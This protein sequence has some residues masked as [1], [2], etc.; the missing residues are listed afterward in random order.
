MSG[1]THVF[2]TEAAKAGLISD[3][4]SANNPILNTGIDCDQNLNTINPPFTIHPKRHP[5]DTGYSVPEAQLW[6]AIYIPPE[7]TYG[8]ASKQPV[9]LV[10]GTAA[11]GG[12]THEGN[13]AK[14]LAGSNSRTLSLTSM[15]HFR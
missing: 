8:T 2:I 4:T 13:F 6:A 14:V 5:S 10:K 9:I 12:S 1:P 7:F 3:G 15:V 11:P